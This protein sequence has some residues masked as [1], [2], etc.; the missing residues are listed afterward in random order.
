LAEAPGWPQN[1]EIDLMEQ[2]GSE[3]S[4]IH[5]AVHTEAFNHIKG[6]QPTRDIDVPDAITQHKIYTRKENELVPCL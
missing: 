2:I 1:G 4:K 6:N 5:S 3:P